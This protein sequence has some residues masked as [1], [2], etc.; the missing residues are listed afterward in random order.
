MFVHKQYSVEHVYKYTH[1]A[2]SS[3]YKNKNIKAFIQ[4]FD[5]KLC[6]VESSSALRELGLSTESNNALY[7]EL[8]S[9]RE[10][11]EKLIFCFFY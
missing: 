4:L 1:Y 10:P 6:T 7:R 11:L 3:E 5:R 9:S 2:H 8:F